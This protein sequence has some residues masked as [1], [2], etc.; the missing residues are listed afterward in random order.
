MD[1]EI[2]QCCDNERG[3]ACLTSTGVL[4][5]RLAG[6]MVAMSGWADTARVYTLQL[7][8]VMLVMFRGLQ[9][10]ELSSNTIA[11]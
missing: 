7:R 3:V 5:H 11:E 1:T 9:A 6:S 10:G 2:S 4:V 8:V